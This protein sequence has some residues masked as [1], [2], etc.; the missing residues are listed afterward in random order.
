VGGVA[1]CHLDREREYTDAAIFEAVKEVIG[2]RAN[3][4]TRLMAPWTDEEIRNLKT[5][6]AKLESTNAELRAALSAE[7]STVVD[8]PRIPLRSVREIN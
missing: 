8:L 7:R 6:M 4:R 5:E 1:A 3:S 2:A